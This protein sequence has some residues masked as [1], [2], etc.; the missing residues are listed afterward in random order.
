MAHCLGIRISENSGG[1]PRPPLRTRPLDSESPRRPRSRNWSFTHCARTRISSLTS[2]RRTLPHEHPQLTSSGDLRPQP[3]SSQQAGSEHALDLLQTSPC[4]VVHSTEGRLVVR[5]RAPELLPDTYTSIVRHHSLAISGYRF[6]W[7]VKGEAFTLLLALG[8]LQTTE[9]RVDAAAMRNV[10][11]MAFLM[12]CGLVETGLT[13]ERRGWCIERIVGWT[14]AGGYRGVNG[15]LRPSLTFIPGRRGRLLAH[16][17]EAALTSAITRQRR[18]RRQP[19]GDVE[20]PATRL[21]PALCRFCDHFLPAILL[22][23]EA[24]N[25]SGRPYTISWT[26]DH[27]VRG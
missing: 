5:D 21:F 26:T 27:N 23:A 3:T 12:L 25:A 7:K 4:A 6:G 1:Y 2:P 9:R 16:A 14:N 18:S 11:G 19:V 13:E 22:R 10:R 20:F 8:V 24:C 17:G 15:G